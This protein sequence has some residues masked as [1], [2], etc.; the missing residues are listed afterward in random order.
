MKKILLAVFSLV[1]FV[2]PTVKAADAAEFGYCTK[3]GGVMNTSGDAVGTAYGQALEIP[4][5]TAQSFDGSKIVGVSVGFGTA[6]KCEVEVFISTNLQ[7]DPLYSQKATVKPNE[8]T[9]V[10]LDT[11]YEIVGKRVYVGYKF[12][13]TSSSDCPMAFDYDS[14]NKSNYGNWVSVAVDASQFNKKWEHYYANYG[15]CCVRALIEGNISGDASAVP[16]SVELPPLARP[17]RD[18]TSVLKVLNSSTVA[19]DDV[20]IGWTAGNNSGIF[21]WRFENPVKG[22]ATGSVNV[23]MVCD[24]EG[25]DVACSFRVLKVNGK[26]NYDSS[27]ELTASLFNSFSYAVR[28]VLVEKNTG[29]RCGWCPRGIVGFREMEEQIT[30]GSFI[31]VAVHN[32]DYPSD[33]MAC[34]S[35]RNWGFKY[36]NGA[37]SGTSNREGGIIDPSYEILMGKYKAQH[38]RTFAE[39]ELETSM[40]G[41]FADVSANVRFYKDINNAD[42]GVGFILTEDGLGPYA[43]NNNYANGTTPMGGFEK[44]NS[45]VMLT[46]DDVAREIFDWEGDGSV[47]PSSIQAGTSYPV[48][49]SLSL[50]KCTKPEN[51]R[52]I[53]FLTDR[54]TGYIVNSIRVRLGNSTGVDN[55]VES[56]SPVSVVCSG[57]VLSADGDFTSAMVYSAD[58]TT[59]AEMISGE[60]RTLNPGIY[61][62]KIA[63]GSSDGKIFKV[64]AR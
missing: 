24:E 51:V 28:N 5:V 63:G 12:V 61:V 43:Q 16:S 3:F 50:E 21:E 57:N 42:Y 4:T 30:D 8:F 6:A 11:P 27:K 26:D 49:K 58:G 7:K 64:I 54:K 52:V 55:V 31:P 41:S 10:M 20:E 14:A 60:R 62:I 48:S 47:I 2:M 37:P 29:T 23:P 25:E 36:S 33:P 38:V 17:G 56:V 44:Q 45:V 35:Y 39:I 1:A 13:S 53:A 46:Y 59:V 9:N 18:F 34:S 19:I 32:Y 22:G 15:N 40:A